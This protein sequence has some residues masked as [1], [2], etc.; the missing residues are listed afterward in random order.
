MGTDCEESL[1]DQNE[2]VLNAKKFDSLYQKIQFS[3]TDDIDEIGNS[4]TS[5]D[6]I[7]S[8]DEDKKSYTNTVNSKEFRDYLKAKGLVIFPTRPTPTQ[9][10]LSNEKFVPSMSQKRRVT[11]DK[12]KNVF[13]RFTNIFSKNKTA[14]KVNSS[15]LNDNGSKRVTLVPS[16]SFNNYKGNSVITNINYREDEDEDEDNKSSISSVLSAAE[17]DFIKDNGRNNNVAFINYRKIDLNKS[18]IY[19]RINTDARSNNERY[20]IKH[21]KFERKSQLPNSSQ[22]KQYV[23]TTSFKNKT[24]AK[25][26]NIGDFPVQSRAT[27]TP[28]TSS[29]TV[30]DPFTFAKLHEIKRKTD[31]VLMNR[32]IIQAPTKLNN[33][34]SNS[35]GHSQ[36]DTM[37]NCE[38]SSLYGEFTYRQPN[39]NNVNVIMRRPDSSTLDRK[40]VMQKIYEYYRKSVNN[41]PVN[42]ISRNQNLQQLGF[43]P[44]K[45]DYLKPSV[46]YN[47]KTNFIRNDANAK[48]DINM[49]FRV[50]QNTNRQSDNDSSIYDVVYESSSASSTQHNSNSNIY[51]DENAKRAKNMLKYHMAS[52]TQNRQSRSNHL[53]EISSEQLKKRTPSFLMAYYLKHQ[54]DSINR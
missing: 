31:E 44:I 23:P 48:A 53:P 38:N 18:K 30:M 19:K 12:K 26:E 47:E 17:D 25:I 52:D 27:S 16:S 34:D 33:L 37:N 20:T 6:D 40:Q 4:P 28:N 14:P 42:T 15:A 36:L 43:S 1:Y 11:F 7:M 50:L 41:T 2:V 39:G 24:S 51:N 10:S 49:S 3:S 5:N 22:D 29:S 9:E 32:S 46:N 8:K 54:L 45:I 13:D 21:N 35:L